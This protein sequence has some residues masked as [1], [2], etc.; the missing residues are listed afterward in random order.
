MKAEL[1]YNRERLKILREHAIDD[2]DAIEG[3]RAR[4]FRRTQYKCLIL[5]LFIIVA[6][7][8]FVNLGSAA[9]YGTLSMLIVAGLIFNGRDRDMDT[10][11]LLELLR[12]LVGRR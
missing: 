12:E 2:P 8:P 10:E 11:S 3:R 9:L 4:R 1:D 6:M 7:A 5:L